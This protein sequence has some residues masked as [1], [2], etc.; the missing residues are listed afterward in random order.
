MSQVFILVQ[1]R[2][3]Y[4]VNTAVWRSSERTAGGSQGHSWKYSVPLHGKFI[5]SDVTGDH[6]QLNYLN[7][8]MKINC[9]DGLPGHDSIEHWVDGCSKTEVWLHEVRRAYWL[10]NLSKT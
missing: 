5:Y 9:P 3:T 1:V 2:S 6:K 8:L 10:Q 7:R 4:S